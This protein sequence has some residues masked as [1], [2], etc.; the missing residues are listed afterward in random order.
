MHSIPIPILLTLHNLLTNYLFPVFC[1]ACDEEGEWVCDE[2][3]RFLQPLVQLF[4]PI[5]HASTSCGEVCNK[6]TG[7]S[8][9]TG[10]IAALKYKEDALIGKIIHILKYNY[11][12][13][14]MSVIRRIL[15]EFIKINKDYFYKIDIIIPVPLHKK[16]YAERGFNQAEY[17]AR[18]LSDELS[19]SM[20]NNILTRS[21]NT[22]HQAKLDRGGRLKNVEGAF[23]FTKFESIKEKHILLVDDV[24]TTGA[25][26]QACANILQKNGASAVSACTLARG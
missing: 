15:H 4:C 10:H 7:K 11:A 18:V 3:F 24:F 13:D 2:C 12:E 17:I 6:C 1:L 25:T 5:C 23:S 19:I 20:K 14:V 8:Y 21:L 26:M 9:L 16:R 22:P